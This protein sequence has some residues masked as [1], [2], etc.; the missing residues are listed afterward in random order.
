MG[1]A[2]L[3]LALAAGAGIAS[4]I[5]TKARKRL[6]I[7]EEFLESRMQGRNWWGGYRQKV[8]EHGHVAAPTLFAGYPNQSPAP[9]R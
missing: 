7:D 8:V 3:P 1:A 4:F 6:E 5:T 2:L 9:K